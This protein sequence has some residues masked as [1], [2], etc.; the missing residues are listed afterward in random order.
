MKTPALTLL[1][2]LTSAGCSNV[3]IKDLLNDVEKSCTRDYTFI[4]S[5]GTASIGANGSITGTL[6]CKPTDPN[7]PLP[8]AT[9]TP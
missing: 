7:A 2:A 9:G 3:Q 8:P 4:L 1:F 5:S 6:H